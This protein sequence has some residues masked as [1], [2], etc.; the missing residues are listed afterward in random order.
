MINLRRATFFATLFFMGLLALSGCRTSQQQAHRA[1]A[2]KNASG[3]PA[4]SRQMDSLLLIEQK[5]IEVIDSMTDLVKADHAR[6]R[7]LEEHTQTMQTSSATPLPPNDPYPSPATEEPHETYVPPAATTSAAFQERYNSALHLYNENNFKE[8]LG[9]F[10]S[11]E[12]DDPNGTYAGNYKYWE[13]ECYY[14]EKRYNMAVQTFGKVLES[15]PNSIKVAAAEFK[16]GECYERLNLPQSA[17]AAYEHLI[18]DYP[19]SEYRARAEARLKALKD[20]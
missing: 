7:A 5:L 2:G 10:K 15:F 17:R 18:A 20:E 8:A 13:G 11:L 1:N 6:I 12:Q 4:L 3:G 9:E 19:S 16:I 14:A